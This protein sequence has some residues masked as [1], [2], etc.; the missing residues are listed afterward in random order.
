MTRVASLAAAACA[1]LATAC[2]AGH[3]PPAA[4]GASTPA[5]V[6]TPSVGPAAPTGPPP[7]PGAEYSGGGCGAT[8]LLRGAAPGWASFANPPSTRYALA[9]R[10]RAAGFLSEPGEIYPSEIV[11]PSPGCWHFTLS[12][13]GH[14]DTV[15]LWYVRH[16]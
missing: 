1:I 16:R 2:T 7:V 14:T 13:N 10:G 11:V 3:P 8:R 9:E 5:S 6:S 4:A 15:D 12:W